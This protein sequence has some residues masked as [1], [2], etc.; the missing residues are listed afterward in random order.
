M[1]KAGL[2]LVISVLILGAIW[3]ALS[4][5]DFVGE[6]GVEKYSRDAEEKLGELLMKQVD[7]QYRK[8]RHDTLAATIN[9][10]YLRIC[11]A[12]GI[13][14]DTMAVHIYDSN[15]VN[16]FVLPGRQIVIFTGLLKYQENAEEFAGV[17]AHEIAHIQEGHVMDRLRRELGT[18]FIL[19]VIGMD[20][21]TE[22]V[23]NIL[24]MLTSSAFSREQESEADQKAVEYLTNADIDPVH[25]ANF[26]IRMA[27]DESQGVRPPE[28]LNTHPDTRNRAA[29][30]LELRDEH[31]LEPEPLISREWDRLLEWDNMGN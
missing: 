10:I 5:I 4:R 11:E 27:A 31:E 7:F 13:D 19:T 29:K 23:A 26:L 3:F 16:A 18:T 21:N 14:P 1:K 22:L 2:Q 6:A 28:W 17:L 20:A 24:R 9:D 30:I 12:N 25:M 15:T 8:S